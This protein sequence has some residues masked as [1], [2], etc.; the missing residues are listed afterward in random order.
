[1]DE[2]RQDNPALSF[3][4]FPEPSYDEWQQAA[5]DSLKGRPFDKLI[6][7]TY[8]GIPLQPLYRREDT[9][10]L[11]FPDTLPDRPPYV[12]GHRVIG[13]YLYG[14]RIGEALG[15]GRPADFN[16]LLTVESPFPEILLDYPTK[17]GLDPD[18][19]P[20]DDVG[21]DGLSLTTIE[22]AIVAFHDFIPFNIFANCGASALPVVALLVAC[23]KKN[24]ILA[25]P[26]WTPF[27]TGM[28]GC[29]AADPLGVLAEEGTLPLSLD[30][31]YDQMAHLARWAA[32][33]TTKLATVAVR[34]DIY[35][36][37][38]ANA[39]QELALGLAT[40]VAYLRA[41]FARVG[42]INIAAKSIRFQFAIGGQFFM[43]IAKL[44]AMRLLWTQVMDS[45]GG[46]ESSSKFHIHARTARRN[47]SAIDPHVN[48]L[49][50]T[51]EA[52]AAI[53]GGADTINVAS[54]DEPLGMSNDFSR[55]IALNVQFILDDEAHLTQFIDP[56]G[57]SYAVETLT[58]DMAHAAWALFQE[59]ERQ[60]GMLAALQS[61]FVQS[62]IAAVAG[63]RAAALATRRDVLVG[64]NQFANPTEKPR[65]PASVKGNSLYLER[66]AQLA[67]HRSGRNANACAATLRELANAMAVAPERVVEAAVAAAEAGATLGEM[68]SALRQKDKLPPN[69][70]PI[71]PIRLA[72]PYEAL[73]RGA[74]A[75][76]DHGHVPRVFLANLGPPRQHKA[77][78]DF[79]QGFFE[80]GGF[81]VI[82]N[83]GFPTPE[84]AA[85]AALASGAPAVVICSTDETYPEL[86]PP[87]V[88]AIRKKARD[89]V[90]I[91]AG[92]PTEQLEALKM[93]GVDEFVYIG[94]DCVAIN[95]WLIERV[96]VKEH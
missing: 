33:R 8:E 88:K 37:A 81:E 45:F 15:S 9:A 21:R 92:R 47:K 67:A 90:I 25:P 96:T 40:G 11:S 10:N 24:E 42:E 18:V 44:R 46:N 35:H 53:V 91:L 63:K 5:V 58:N 4:E 76:A 70:T 80:V 2:S 75:G 62:S 22:D 12:R 82:T 43:E 23:F 6:T 56:A 17:Q 60:G 74:W 71:R 31:A 83:N 84:E 93:A 94:A 1:M 55:R 86:V 28:Y 54:F 59:I 61:G 29:L 49:R 66:A 89:T 77:R 20:V 3:D 7:P 57:G 68:A 34:T 95:E 64:V 73:R 32:F 19:A 48:M 52:L 78:A 39:V 79:A 85:A 51:T 65:L 50:A 72:A 30:E 16:R 41:Q 26:E 27:A 14:R 69:I 13:K 36:E 87:L 38:G